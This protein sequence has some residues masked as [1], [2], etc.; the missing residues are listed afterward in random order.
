MQRFLQRG[1]LLAQPR[2]SSWQHECPGSAQTRRGRL[3]VECK[4]QSRRPTKVQKPAVAQPNG[5]CEMRLHRGHG[6]LHA[7]HAWLGGL[8]G[9]ATPLGHRQM[10]RGLLRS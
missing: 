3:L 6:R 2:G 8:A 5:G 1:G 4:K 10:G 9:R 7:V